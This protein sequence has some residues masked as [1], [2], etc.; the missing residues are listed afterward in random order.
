[1]FH[2]SHVLTALTG[3]AADENHPKANDIAR[4]AADEWANMSEEERIA[5][6]DDVLAKME[7]LRENRKHAAHSSAIAAF[8]DTRSTMDRWDEEVCLLCIL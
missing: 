5:A 8:H 2:T 1:M 6:T 7:E 4:E 3:L